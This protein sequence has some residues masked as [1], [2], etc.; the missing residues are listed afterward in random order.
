MGMLKKQGNSL[1]HSP[2]RW[3]LGL[4]TTLENVVKT[5]ISSVA[6]NLTQLP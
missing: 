4:S 5:K 3:L 2:H 1:H 6:R